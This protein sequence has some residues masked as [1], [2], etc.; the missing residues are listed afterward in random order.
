MCKLAERTACHKWPQGVPTSR[1][2]GT[3]GRRR[4]NLLQRHV[5]VQ[6]DLARGRKK[7]LFAAAIR[8]VVNG[9]ARGATGVVGPA[10]S[11]RTRPTGAFAVSRRAIRQPSIGQTIPRTTLVVALI[12]VTLVLRVLFSLGL[13]A[14]ID[15]SYTVATSRHL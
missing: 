5:Q 2:R 9:L 1:S 11:A 8:A 6:D 4:G 10:L 12:V 14:G 15:E 3:P 7:R 13:G